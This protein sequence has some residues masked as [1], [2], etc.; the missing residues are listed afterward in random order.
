MVGTR[1]M[2]LMQTFFATR[3]GSLLFFKVTFMGREGWK[4]I[5]LVGWP[6]EHRIYDKNV[7]QNLIIVGLVFKMSE[8]HAS[9]KCYIKCFENTQKDRAVLLAKMN[10]RLH[11]S[12]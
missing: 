11:C 7:P 10:W 8:D 12:Q 3:S 1:S 9:L 5:H 2:C 6:I 4:M